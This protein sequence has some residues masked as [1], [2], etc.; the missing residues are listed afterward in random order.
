VLDEV[1]VA[2]ILSSSW[3][4]NFFCV[5]RYIHDGIFRSIPG[6]NGENT[7]MV[8]GMVIRDIV[9]SP[10]PRTW[11]PTDIFLSYM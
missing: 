4:S 9:D 5:D 1:D 10:V 3:H 2:N 8:D 11:S 6:G 7:L